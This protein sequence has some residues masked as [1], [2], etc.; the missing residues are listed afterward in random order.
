MVSQNFANQGRQRY[1]FPASIDRLA[2][3]FFLFLLLLSLEQGET[4]IFRTVVC[5]VPSVYLRRMTFSAKE[6]QNHGPFKI[7]ERK[8]EPPL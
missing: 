6:T 4:S 1:K 8:A 5:F 7:I 2:Q 3:D